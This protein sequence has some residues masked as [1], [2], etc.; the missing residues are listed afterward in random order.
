MPKKKQEIADIADMPTVVDNTEIYKNIRGIIVDAQHK[1][2]KAVN[3]AMV[4]AYWNIGKLIYEASGQ[5][6][7]AEYGKE[8][9]QYLS[10]QLT[11]EFGKGFDKSNLSNMR[12]FYVSFPILDTLCQELSWSHY[13]LLMKSDVFFSSTRNEVLYA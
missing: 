11:T 13:R 1:V 12:K 8:L 2:Y 5:Q 6:K 10:K 7:R 3:F 9:L 4:L